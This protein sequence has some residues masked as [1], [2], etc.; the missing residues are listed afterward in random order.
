M[1]ENL[2]FTDRCIAK[3]QHMSV[4]E[5]GMASALSDYLERHGRLI[6]DAGRNLFWVRPPSGAMQVAVWMM[7]ACI[8]AEAA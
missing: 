2:A 6:Y 7:P 1:S 4:D 8:A 3:L 5:G